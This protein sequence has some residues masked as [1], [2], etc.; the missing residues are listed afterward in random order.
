LYRLRSGRKSGGQKGHEGR[1]LERWAHPDREI[2]LKL[3][4]CPL[5]GVE[6]ADEHIVG[7]I[8]RQVFEL[9]PASLEAIQYNCRVYEVPGTAARAHAGFPE[10]VEAPVQYG[11]RFLA[12]L[13][14]MAD[15][16]LLPLRRIRRMCQ[17]L[18]GCPVSEGTIAAARKRCRGNLGE[19]VEAL[20]GRLKG[21][22]VLHADE[23]GMRVGSGNAWLHSLSTERDTLYHIDPKRGGEAVERMGVLEGFSNTLV[24]DFWKPYL[25]L[26]CD[27]AICNAHIVRELAYFEDLGEAWARKL[28]KLL[29]EASAEPES[30]SLGQCRRLYR[31]HVAEGFRRNPFKPPPRK[32]GERGRA[33]RPKVVNLLDRLEQ[34]EDWILAFLEDRSIPFTNNQAERDVR[35]AKLK[36]K[37]SGCLRSWEGGETFATIRSYIST[38][39]KREA[40]VIDALSSAISGKAE[41]FT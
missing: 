14:Y 17:D 28:R 18:F 8:Q 12:W 32:P 26:Q 39:I 30:R 27:H 36:Q 10:G 20:E 9:P 11:P 25:G 15:F 7:C 19:F 3:E 1:T 2:E 24:H 40:S 5:T 23:T 34:Y 33:A 41:I 37:I 35:M 31:K 16:Q 13:V 4:T 38:C 22:P 6:L 29:L 21:E